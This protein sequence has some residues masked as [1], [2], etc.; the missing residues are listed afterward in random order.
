MASLLHT[1][2]G[3]VALWGLASNRLQAV[4]ELGGTQGHLR[5]QCINV[6]A[7]GL[8]LF[9]YDVHG[10]SKEVLV[11]SREFL[12]FV[13]TRILISLAQLVERHGNFIQTT[14]LKCRATALHYHQ[15]DGHCQQRYADDDNDSAR[16]AGFSVFI[17]QFGV[18]EFGIVASQQVGC[19][20]VVE[21]VLQQVKAFKFQPRTIG[22]DGP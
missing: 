11:A 8:Y 20:I 18:A 3:N 2:V 17:S 13:G 22:T 9:G 15:H 6:D 16:M 7:V 14:A 19:S 1:D 21:R 12:L 10:T 4:T 5:R